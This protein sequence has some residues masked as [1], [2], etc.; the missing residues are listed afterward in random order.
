MSHW[1]PIPTS[2][3]QDYQL[4]LQEKENNS[5]VVG[6]NGTPPSS[7]KISKTGRGRELKQLNPSAPAKCIVKMRSGSNGKRNRAVTILLSKDTDFLEHQVIPSGFEAEDEVFVSLKSSSDAFAVT[8]Q[9]PKITRKWGLCDGKLVKKS[10]VLLLKTNDGW[11]SIHVKVRPGIRGS[12]PIFQISK[13]DLLPYEETQQTPKTPESA[14]ATE[15]D[16]NPN[17]NTVLEI[18][19][20][21]SP[22]PQPELPPVVEGFY[23]ADQLTPNSPFADCISMHFGSTSLFAE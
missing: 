7:S 23:S 14:S 3:G 18:E 12:V 4:L 10:F 16:N 1:K 5:Q 21:W 11:A 6:V 2:P 22:K 8:L 13:E 17:L 20:T 15:E 19:S 9:A